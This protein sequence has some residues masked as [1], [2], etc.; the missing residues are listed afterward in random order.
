MTVRLR[1]EVRV[2][3]YL[4]MLFARGHFATVIAKGDPDS[5]T[6]LMVALLA[7]GKSLLFE[8]TF[9]ISP[10]PGHFEIGQSSDRRSW[11]L[12]SNEPLNSDA[13]A[14]KLASRRQFDPDLWII[15]VEA[16]KGTCF[17]PGDDEPYDLSV[18][19]DDRP[20]VGSD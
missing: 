9:E 15:E 8:P 7:T 19:D 14:T 13:L 6:L 4:R 20:I 17:L 1:T 10:A 11:Q 18:W 12:I 3:G 16:S 2:S 5:G